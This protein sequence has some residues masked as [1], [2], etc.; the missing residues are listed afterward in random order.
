MAWPW[1]PESVKLREKAQEFEK[2]SSNLKENYDQL[3]LD[4]KSIEETKISIINGLKGTGS[5]DSSLEGR[6]YDKFIEVVNLDETQWGLLLAYHQEGINKVLKGST[7]A[8][9]LADK[10]NQLANEA[11]EREKEKEDEEEEK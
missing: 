11:E 6:S 7:D 4:Q 10:Y 8:Q 2:L 9:D 1:S 3:V 5:L